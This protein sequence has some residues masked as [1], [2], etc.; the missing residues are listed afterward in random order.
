MSP[1][2]GVDEPAGAD[3]SLFAIPP[4]AE[5]ERMVEA[6]LFAASAPLTSQQLAARMPEGCDP[7]E[8]IQTLRRR[9][10]AGPSA[11]RLTSAS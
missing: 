6:I 11:P 9:Y 1:E 4:M 2:N 8:A 3:P 7:A 10:R 5:Q